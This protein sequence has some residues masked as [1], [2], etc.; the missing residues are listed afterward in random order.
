M[1][2]EGYLSYLDM[3]LGLPTGTIYGYCKAAVSSRSIER[4][5][6]RFTYRGLATRPVR[7]SSKHFSWVTKR[8]FLIEDK[9]SKEGR[10]LLAQVFLSIPDT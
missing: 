5:E 4:P 2:S 7:V 3:K 6:C 8:V 10:E 9:Y 1:S